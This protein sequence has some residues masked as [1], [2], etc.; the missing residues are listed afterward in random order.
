MSEPI[1]IE[2]LKVSRRQR[3]TDSLSTEAL[4]LMTAGFRSRTPS[5]QLAEQILAATGEMLSERTL[6]R[7]RQEWDAEQ[8]R[9]QA[10]RE[11]MEDLLS[12]MRKG[13]ATASEMVNALALDALMRDPD[14]FSSLDPI[15]VQQT[16]I[17]AERVRIQARRLELQERA[18]ALDEAKFATMQRQQEA[19]IKA[20][21][22]LESKAAAGKQ[23]SPDDIRRIREAYGL[24]N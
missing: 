19:A 7:R 15:A 12:A 13:D 11:Q 8:L 20:A 21:E 22:E 6:Y 17:A 5:A 18:I 2:S 1:E 24:S 23:V 3:I 4:R 16:S 14:G 9:R 10:G